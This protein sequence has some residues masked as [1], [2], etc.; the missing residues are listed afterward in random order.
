MKKL[1]FAANT[2]DLG[3]I[4]R[5][6]VT[7]LNYLASLGKYELVL[8]LEKKQGIFL[9]ELDK[10]IKIIEYAPCHNKPV[11]LRK[12]INA[13]KRL[14]FI[15]CYKNKFDFA[16]SFAT[17]SQMSSFVARTASKNSAL[18]GHA[19]YLEL[20][21][22]NKKM[23][24]EFF[25][26]L[27]YEQFNKFVFV[28]EEGKNS[29]ISVFPEQEGKVHV[30][31]NLIDAE[32]IRNLANEE[33]D[34]VKEERITFLNVGR[35]EEVQKC[36]TRLIEA[37]KKLKQDGYVFRVL[38]VGDGPDNEQYRNLVIEAKLDD[39][40][41]FLGRKKNPYPYFKFCDAV[42]LTSE[43]EGYPVVFL[44]SMVLAKTIITT[45]VS[46]SSSVEEGGY[47]IVTKKSTNE[48]YKAMRQFI[49]K[50]YTPKKFDAESFNEKLKERMQ[51]IID[52]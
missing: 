36:L 12:V 41:F 46:G 38:M 44:E 47:G 7:W 8:V 32:N 49:E 43:Y 2:L 37:S 27:H 6:L 19:D 28:S 31:N 5:A 26:N 1:L 35:H 3:G 29:F 23:M 50:G 16:V 24:R 20:Y 45:A 14:A 30:C 33:I 52:I 9:E 34:F 11:L 10:K 51:Q 42:V 13:I 4:E 21:Q 40:I 18:W 48:I 39:T 17:Y 25:E 22:G 15:C